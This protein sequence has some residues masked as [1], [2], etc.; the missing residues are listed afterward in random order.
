ML[1]RRLRAIEERLAELERTQIR[2]VAGPGIHLT[3]P[4]AAGGVVCVSVD[5][6]QVRAGLASPPPAPPAEEG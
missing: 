5:L 2:V 1:L 4:Q 6:D 3:P